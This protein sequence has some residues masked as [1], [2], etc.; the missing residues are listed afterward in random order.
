MARNRRRDPAHPDLFR[1]YTPPKVVKRYEPERMRAATISMRLARAVAEAMRI[2]GRKRSEIAA[3]MSEFLGGDPV[4]EAMLNQYA[5][6]SN[7]RHNIPA[8]R[9]IAL[10]VVTGDPRLINA[11]LTDTGLIAVE[12]KYEALIHREMAKEARD[13][14]DREIAAADARWRAG[15]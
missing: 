4:T 3:A 2:D 5:A 14:L 7:D 8:H 6:P 15:Q 13:K 11:A 9:L 10:L 12:E 1:D